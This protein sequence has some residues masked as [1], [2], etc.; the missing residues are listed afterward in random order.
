[1]TYGF[2][3]NKSKAQVYTKSEIDTKLSN[4]FNKI[5]FKYI[6]ISKEVTVPANGTVRV[7]FTDGNTY[8]GY[9]G[10]CFNSID[11]N[12]PSP[13]ISIHGFDATLYTDHTLAATITLKNTGSSAV[14]TEVVAG[15]WL[16]KE[17]AVID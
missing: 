13:N 1:M 5:G 8:T 4:L 15:L 6:T 9:G 17:A 2:N 3:D 12:D 16:I 11:Y 14:V 7:N 10:F